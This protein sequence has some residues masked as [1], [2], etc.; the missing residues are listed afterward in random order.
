MLTHRFPEFM[1]LH[2][3]LPEFMCPLLPLEAHAFPFHPSEPDV[4]VLN[5]FLGGPLDLSLLSLYPDHVVRDMW[6]GEI[7]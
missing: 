7:S 1:C 2:H 6:K 3:H 4:V 5:G